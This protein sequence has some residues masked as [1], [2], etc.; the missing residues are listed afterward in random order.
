MFRKYAYILDILFEENFSVDNHDRHEETIRENRAK[1]ANKL[2][3]SEPARVSAKG[4]A[5]AKAKP[6]KASGKASAK[7]DPRDAFLC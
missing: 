7:V 3:A 6:T 4:K 2:A 5:S 1:V